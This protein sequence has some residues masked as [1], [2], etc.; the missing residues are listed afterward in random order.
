MP[1]SHSRSIELPPDE[2]LSKEE[3]LKLWGIVQDRIDTLMANGRDAVSNLT[4]DRDQEADAIDVA[5]SESER[6]FVLRLADRERLMLRKL[7]KAQERMEEG[8]YGMCESC[9]EP[10]TLKRLMVRPVATQCIDCKTQ[11]EQLERRS[12]TF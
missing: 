10:I 8:E 3:V 2:Y 6:E 11:A 12:R 7:K 1:V 5:S 9:G 4:E